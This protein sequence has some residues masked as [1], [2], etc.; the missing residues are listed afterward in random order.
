MS[1]AFALDAGAADAMP[2][3]A[4]SVGPPTGAT[5]GPAGPSPV[6][7]PGLPVPASAGAAGTAATP[8]NSGHHALPSLEAVLKKAGERAPQVRLGTAALDV[9]QSSYTNARRAPLGNPYFEIVG[10]HGSNNVTQGI[11]VI[12]TLWLPFEV[13]G[14]RG[15]RMAE[16]EAYVGLHQKTL[17]TARASALGEAVNAYGVAVVAAERVRV[18]EEVV[19]NS[20]TTA[21]LYEARLKAGDAILRDATIARVELSKNEVLLQDAYGR[22]AMAFTDLSRLTGERYDGI[23]DSSVTPP[24]LQV[25]AYLERSSKELPPAVAAAEAEANYF[26]A[27][28]DRLQRESYGNIQLMLVGGR[29]D[30]GETRLGAGIAYEVPAFRTNQGD[31]ARAQAERLRAQTEKAV[32]QSYIDTRLSGL[33]QQYKQLR[34]AHEV[35]AQVAIP[36]ANEAVAASQA[37]LQAGKEDWF[38]VLMTRRDQ[39]MLKLQSLELLERQWLLLGELVHLTGELP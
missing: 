18:L 30:V 26:A 22:M 33:V 20:K 34:K 23:S 27:Q 2:T 5:N 19:R 36:A 13:V 29:G 32:R 39:A 10:Q 11:S 38:I 16:A 17:E 3:M 7:A 21:D 35:M 28:N 8:V 6:S 15:Q 31:K 4:P 25:D 1:L 12:G 37:T 24:D 9:S 14:Q